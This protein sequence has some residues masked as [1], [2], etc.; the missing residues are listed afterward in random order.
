MRGVRITLSQ[1]WLLGLGTIF[2]VGCAWDAISVTPI[3]PFGPDGFTT[4]ASIVGGLPGGVRSRVI[5]EAS[6]F[7]A[8]AG[9]RSLPLEINLITVSSWQHSVTIVFRCF[10]P[11]GLVV[12]PFSPTTEEEFPH[13]PFSSGISMVAQSPLRVQW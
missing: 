2:C 8:L 13:D 9:E 1:G 4:S 3:Y 10:D 7:C 6:D 11:A 12:P 5:A